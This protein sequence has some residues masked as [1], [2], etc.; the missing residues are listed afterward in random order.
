MVVHTFY[1]ST[2]R[3]AD[4]EFEV[5]L[6]YRAS[7]KTARATQRNPVLIKKERKE[8]RKREREREKERERERERKCLKNLKPK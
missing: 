7:S 6:V 1:L 2:Q 8:E 4:L 5:S 3:Q